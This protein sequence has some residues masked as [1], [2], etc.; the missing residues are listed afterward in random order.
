MREIFSK[1]G[2]F[3][4]YGEKTVKLENGHEIVHR[5]ENPTELWWELKEA[6]KGRRVRVVVYELEES[7]EK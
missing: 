7:G 2:V 4:R 6:L 5:S 1:E 3:V